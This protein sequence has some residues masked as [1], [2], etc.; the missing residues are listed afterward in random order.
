MMKQNPDDMMQ[1]RVGLLETHSSGQRA[2]KSPQLWWN[3]ISGLW[4]SL[5]GK[6]SCHHALCMR[7]AQAGTWGSI[8]GLA[9]PVAWWIL[10]WDVSLPTEESWLC[11]SHICPGQLRELSPCLAFHQQGM[12]CVRAP[13]YFSAKYWESASFYEPSGIQ[14]S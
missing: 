6:S 1:G 12:E 7:S 10:S 14:S 5:G 2:K 9:A 11:Q 13:G 8:C 3:V 4:P